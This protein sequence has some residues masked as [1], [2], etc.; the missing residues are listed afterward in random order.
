MPWPGALDRPLG[1]LSGGQVVRAA[2]ASILVSRQGIL[3]P[4][5]PTHNLDATG[6]ISWGTRAAFLGRRHGRRP[7]LNMNALARAGLTPTP[8]VLLETRSETGS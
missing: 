5:E 1:R 6:G 3:L 8:V 2:L 7:D 4:D